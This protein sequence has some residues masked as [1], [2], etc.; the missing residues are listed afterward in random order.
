MK[1]FWQQLKF[2]SKRLVF[3]NFSFVFFSVLLPALFYILYT[4]VLIWGSA[5]Q[6]LAFAKTYL[7]SMIVYSF[8]I[9]ACFGLAQL[10]KSDYD[11]KYLVWLLLMPR[12]LIP[13]YFSIT[14]IMISIN[15][16]SLG[17]LGLCAFIVHG[18]SFTLHQ[19][20][21]L[22]G[23]LMITQLP[24][25]ILGYAMSFIKRRETLSILSNL[26]VF[27]LAVISGL[28]WPIE[29]LP[30]W[31]Q[32]IGQIMPTY[33]ANQWFNCVMFKQPLAGHYLLGILVWIII[34]LILVG[35]VRLIIKRRGVILRNE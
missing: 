19:W 20:L 1:I 21:L 12:G 16:F 25:L 24:S 26:I 6:V 8:L 30:K 7:G 23:V 17:F 31:L 15:V 35:G 3:R 33:Y 10:L 11:H 29:A 5:T 27:P 9:S 2:D 13:Y 4:K 32:P 34:G 22:L 28:W 14:L 18:I